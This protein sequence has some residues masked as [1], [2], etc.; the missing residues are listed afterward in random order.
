[1]VFESLRIYSWTVKQPAVVCTVKF[2]TNLETS[3]MVCKSMFYT[4][5]ILF[6]YDFEKAGPH[7]ECAQVG[8]DLTYMQ[9][10]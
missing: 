7:A 5:S 8:M 6:Q 4:A 2:Y 1:M 9:I 10:I 3:R